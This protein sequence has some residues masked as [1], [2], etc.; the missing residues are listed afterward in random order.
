MPLKT[1]QGVILRCPSSHPVKP[2]ASV[3]AIWGGTEEAPTLRYLP[4]AIPISGAD[5]ADA[6]TAKARVTAPCDGPSCANFD[7]VGCRLPRMIVEALP[8]VT[9][10]LPPCILRASCVWFHQEG[11]EA[12]F[13]CPQILRGDPQG[14]V[15]DAFRKLEED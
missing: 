4:A 9:D 13:R 5:D 14:T 6:V 2:R 10:S 12:C 15:Q 3:F 11:K 7:G 1:P 8:V